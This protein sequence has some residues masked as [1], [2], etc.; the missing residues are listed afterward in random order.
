MTSKKID[1]ELNVRSSQDHLFMLLR[2]WREEPA[3][4][5]GLSPQVLSTVLELAKAI[6]INPKE[7]KRDLQK[8]APFSVEET[9]S[10]GA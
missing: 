5:A 6:S 2:K 7:F 1:V 9:K 4:A 8:I 3:L 10:H